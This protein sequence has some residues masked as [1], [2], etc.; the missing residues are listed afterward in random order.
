MRPDQVT[1]LASKGGVF[2]LSVVVRGV[3]ADFKFDVEDLDELHRFV[4]VAVKQRKEME[5]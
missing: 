4:E 3:H 5:Q 1:A 2:T